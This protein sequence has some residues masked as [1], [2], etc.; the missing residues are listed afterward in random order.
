MG[1]ASLAEIGDLSKMSVSQPV[2]AKKL[3]ERDPEARYLPTGQ[4][5]CSLHKDRTFDINQPLNSE[6][7]LPMSSKF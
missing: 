3:S 6:K 7:R 2:N 1:S 5:A 4:T